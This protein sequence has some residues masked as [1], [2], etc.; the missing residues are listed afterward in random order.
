VNK[1]DWRDYA[2]Y[3]LLVAL[4]MFCGMYL[5]KHPS[6]ANF[7]T[8]ELLAGIMIGALRWFDLRDDKEKDAC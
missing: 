3:G 6:D 2:T 4:G 5:W 8:F 1:K 7:G